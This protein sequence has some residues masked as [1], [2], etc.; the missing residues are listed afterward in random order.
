MKHLFTVA[1]IALLGLTSCK[2]NKEFTI[3]GEIEN[4]PNSLK[5][6]YLYK[7]NGVIDS[8]LLNESSKFKFKCTTPQADFY[9]LRID[10]KPFLI[11]A[12]NGE[13]LDFKTNYIDSTGTYVITGSKES[14]RLMDLI[15]MGVDTEKSTRITLAA[16]LKK[17]IKPSN[18]SLSNAPIHHLFDKLSDLSINANDALQREIT[19]FYNKL[20]DDHDKKLLAFA[21]TNKDYLAGFYAVTSVSPEKHGP[22]LIQYAEDI[23]SKFPDN[24]SIQAFATYMIKLKALSIN[25]EAPNFELPTPDRKL[26]KLSDFKGKYVLLDF[27]ASWCIPCRIENPNMVKAYQSFKNKNFTVLSVSLDQDKTKWL[28]VIETDKLTWTHVSDLK[29]WESDVVAKY[30]IQKIPSSFLLNPEGKIIAKNLTGDELK[31]FLEKTLR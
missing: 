17:I 27:W 23:K 1:L 26:I 22:Q 4:C 20:I 31:I 19:Q 14:D 16:L 30:Q 8:T 24:E 13:K 9:E 15:Q 3:S 7:G 21:E 25:S 11:I 18:E 10:Q 28:K 6:V 29:G 5:K 2:N 12:N